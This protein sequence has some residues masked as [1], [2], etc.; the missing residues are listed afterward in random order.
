MDSERTNV[1]EAGSTLVIKDELKSNLEDDCYEK[2]RC[3]FIKEELK[4]EREK[5]RFFDKETRREL[6]D[7]HKRRAIAIMGAKKRAQVKRKNLV[8]RK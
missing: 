4:Y 3:K 7:K 6:R 8:R 1:F 5:N 2:L